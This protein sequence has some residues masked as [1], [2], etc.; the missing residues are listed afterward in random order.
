MMSRALEFALLGVL[1]N[2]PTAL[3]QMPTRPGK[4][5]LTSSPPGQVIVIN[6]VK[7]PEVTDVILIVSPGKYTVKV[8]NCQP[9][10]VPVSSGETK[11]IHCP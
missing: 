9:Q 1:L 8:G 7:R 3:P 6:D 10:E 11:E 4:L 5:H 2:V